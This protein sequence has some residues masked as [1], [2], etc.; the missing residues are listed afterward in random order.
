MFK[1]IFKFIFIT[2]FIILVFGEVS[3]SNENQTNENS[4]KSSEISVNAVTPANNAATSET[5][6]K[7][8]F[9]LYEFGMGRCMQCKKMKPIIE[10]LKNELNGK[11]DVKNHDISEN[12][13]IAEKYK[14]ILIPTQIFLD[15]KE[16]EIFRHEGFYPKEEITAKLKELGAKL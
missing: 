14:V 7:P 6:L 12:K 10:E 3:F 2:G 13:E 4:L 15:S 8:E 11:V 16:N 9:S 5:N 1:N